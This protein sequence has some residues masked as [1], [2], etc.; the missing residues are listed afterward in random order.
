MTTLGMLRRVSKA[1]RNRVGGVTRSAFVAL[2]AAAVVAGALLARGGS[3]AARVEALLLVLL[4]IVLFGLWRRRDRRDW[5]DAARVIRRIIVPAEPALGRRMLRAL[6]LLETTEQRRDLGSAEL[7]RLHLER[8]IALAPIEAVS[9]RATRRARLL[10]AAGLGLSCAVA[11]FGL[12]APWRLLEGF[13]VWLAYRGRAPLPMQWLTET[14]VTVQAP[15]YLRRADRSVLLGWETHQPRGSVVV[16][17]GRPVRDGRTLVLSD[18]ATEVPFVSDGAGGV[19]ARF[20]LD[21]DAKLHVGARFGSVLIAEDEG[22]TLH[23]DPDREPVVSLE[24]APSERNLSEIER[25][26]LRY[27]ARDD[28]G[29][30]Q[31][32]L[33]LESGNRKERRVLLRLDGESAEHRGGHTLEPDDSFFK[34]AFLPIQVSIEAR[35]DDPIHGPKWG[36]SAAIVLLPSPV[37]RPEA[38]RVAA[39]SRARRTLVELLAFLME[40]DPKPSKLAMAEERARV[41]RAQKAVEAQLTRVPSGL[42]VPSGLQAFVRGQLHQIGRSTKARR[43]RVEEAVLGLD[44]AISALST[45]DARGV[46]KRLAEVAED[47][48]RAAGHAR[49][50]EQRDASLKRLD[51]AVRGLT[52][53]AKELARLGALGADIGSVAEGELLRLARARRSENMTHV[54]LI[55]THLAQRLR[56]S[57]PSFGAASRGGVEAGTAGTGMPSAEPTQADDQF[58]ELALELEQLAREHA[59]L[60]AS[61]S[62]TLQDAEAGVDMDALRAEAQERAKALREALGDL[63]VPG[64]DSESAR[65]AAALGREHG[66]AMAGSMERLALRDALESAQAALGA[67]EDAERKARQTG[68]LSGVDE[69]ALGEAKRQVADD[70]AFLERALEQVRRSARERA[71]ESLDAASKHERELGSTAG[72][73]AGRGKHGEAALPDDIVEGL[74]GAQGLMQQAARELRSGSAEKGVELQRQAQRLLERAD[75]GRTT[76]S[77]HGS[78]PD[79]GPDGDSGGRA[80]RTGGEVPGAEQRNRADDFRRRVVRGLG[81]GTQGEMQPAVRRYAEGLLQ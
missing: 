4:V 29:L 75:T 43:V 10:R 77:N 39:L 47:A 65:A 26:E 9:V 15:T 61:V 27:A 21:N 71:S 48:A 59:R 28:H 73:L 63:P 45:R 58:D 16:V 52:D 11:G 24:G 25:L 49:E 18:G 55:A 57:N 69:Q 40:R 76:D 12:F 60:I 17:R 66:T 78:Q 42:D 33:V 3:L 51:L 19:V 13:D 2:I 56:H 14:G 7:A 36:K 68:P 6:S 31:I 81:T 8:Q 34:R 79:Q 44:A 70:K 5:Q 53:G 80:P 64:A 1:W 20:T 46:S 35:D 54:E 37:G 67:L 72:N 74:E 22:L 30:R 41:E 50:S 32:D 62:R 38:E 23:A